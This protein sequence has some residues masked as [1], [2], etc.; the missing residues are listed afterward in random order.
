M[1]LT[2]CPMER[3]RFETW[4]YVYMIGITGP[5]MMQV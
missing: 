5:K 1:A 2:L 4:V 3:G